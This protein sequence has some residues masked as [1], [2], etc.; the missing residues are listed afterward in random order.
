MRI[1]SMLLGGALCAGLLFSGA[2]PT[3]RADSGR[4]AIVRSAPEERAA[5][6]V[7]QPGTGAEDAAYGQREEQS[8]QVQDF[9]GGEVVII[10]GGIILLVVVIILLFVLLSN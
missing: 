4:D 6:A 5:P 8:P 7:A 9:A 2:C 3:A 1:A 10:G